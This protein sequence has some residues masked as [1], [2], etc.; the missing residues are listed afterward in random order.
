MGNV[1]IDISGLKK[2]A[3]KLNKIQMAQFNEAA[4]KELAARLVGKVKMRTPV[5]KSTYHMENTGEIYKRGK[6]KGQA[7]QKRVK[8]HHGGILRLG[9]TVGNVRKTADTYSIDIINPVEYASYVEYGHRTPNHKGWVIGKFMFKI[10]QQELERD[11]PGILERKL[12]RFLSEV[13][14]A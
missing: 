14:N 4:I 12:T 13:F 3:D 10:S 5:G 7:R 1:K 8:D 9:W 11:A 6:K 2:Y